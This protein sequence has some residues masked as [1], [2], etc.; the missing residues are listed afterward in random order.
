MKILHSADLH[1]DTPFAGRSREQAQFLKEELLTVPEKLATLCRQEQCDLFALSGDLFDGPWTKES[2]FA[3]RNALEDCAVPVFISPGNHDYVNLKSPY[4]TELW[5]S[6]V[7][8]FTQPRMEALLL[9]ELDCRVYGAGFRSM[10]CAGLLEGFRRQADARYQIAILH[11]DPTQADSPC[12]PVTADQIRNSGLDYLALGHIHKGGQ[13]RQG[14]TLC[15]WPGCPMGRGFDE[16][17]TKGAL[18]VTL[19]EDA[20]AR[21][22]PL[23]T[24][25]FFEQKTAAEA[26]PQLLPAV[27]SRDFYRITLVGEN[28][29]PSLAELYEQYSRFPHLEFRDRRSAPTNLWGSVDADTLEGVY[30]RLLKDAFEN[31]DAETGEIIELAAR[32]SRQILDGQEVV[33]P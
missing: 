27:G 7:H 20:E 9:E 24:P 10:D 6:N 30:F 21:F 32:L 17:G 15:A 18:L 12:C 8:I 3:L 23:D 31:A 29:T 4:T 28:P 2:F 1:L 16:T 14:R 33:L 25:R 26:L 5:P 22:L 11:G 13:L 19:Q